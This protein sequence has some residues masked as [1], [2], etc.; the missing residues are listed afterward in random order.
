MLKK[1]RALKWWGKLAIVVGV[2]F[3]I[4]ALGVMFGPAEQPKQTGTALEAGTTPLPKD[5]SMPNRSASASTA[6]PEDAPA[7]RAE[8]AL[9][10]RILCEKIGV[11]GRGEVDVSNLTPDEAQLAL[12][13]GAASNVGKALGVDD[14]RSLAILNEA[15]HEQIEKQGRDA[16][17]LQI[18]CHPE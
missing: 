3:T 4:G 16:S 8:K 17:T 1:W 11:L 15:F 13:M 6:S 18:A 7:S 2:W 14:S 9:A 5:L 12:I 10:L